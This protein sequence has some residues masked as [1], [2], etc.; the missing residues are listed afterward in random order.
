MRAICK[1]LKRINCRVFFCTRL[2][3]LRKIYSDRTQPR[4][5]GAHNARRRPMWKLYM[6]LRMVFVLC[7]ARAAGMRAAFA[8]AAA[9]R[10]FAL[11]LA[12]YCSAYDA[13]HRNDAHDYYYNFKN[14]HSYALRLP[15]LGRSI[16][17][18]LYK[19]MTAA[20]AIATTSQMNTVHHQL[21]T[22]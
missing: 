7:L 10:G 16:L 6:L 5:G 22:V 11:Y 17:P 12:V 21:P 4:G 3:H 9:A 1:C 18:R 19:T 20:A 8:P 2:T 13:E 14:S 15:H